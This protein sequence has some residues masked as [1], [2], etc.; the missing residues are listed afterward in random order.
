MMVLTGKAGGKPVHVNPLAI[1]SM[2]TVMFANNKD[3][4][5]SLSMFSGATIL[6]T[7]SIEEIRQMMEVK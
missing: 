3:F 5:T 1:E 2:R 4:C 6:V 7:E